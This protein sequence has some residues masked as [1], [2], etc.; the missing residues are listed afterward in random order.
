MILYLRPSYL[1]KR[2]LS[3]YILLHNWFL[4]LI[5]VDVFLF[6]PVSFVGHRIMAFRCIYQL[7]ATPTEWLALDL[8]LLLLFDF[9]WDNVVRLLN[10]TDLHVSL[11]LN[12]PSDLKYRL[13]KHTLYIY[14][15]F[16]RAVSRGTG[17]AIATRYPA[18]GM[19][20]ILPH[21]RLQLC[22]MNYWIDNVS[23]QVNVSVPCHL[24]TCAHQLA[25]GTG[26]LVSRLQLLSL[27]WCSARFTRTVAAAN[28]IKSP[29]LRVLTQPSI[30]AFVTAHRFFQRPPPA[31]TATRLF[32]FLTNHSSNHIRNYSKLVLDRPLDPEGWK[33]SKLHKY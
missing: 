28:S 24:F 8:F 30:G 9:K 15:F 21:A 31:T 6:Q 18:H 13:L 33:L 16:C 5:V 32:F 4:L 11:Q 1:V 29:R 27:P 20:L 3:T 14:I 26:P 7:K 22:P 2:K 25:T 17:V 10:Q 12:L 23:N 19:R